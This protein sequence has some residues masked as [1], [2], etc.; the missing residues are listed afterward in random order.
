LSGEGIVTFTGK[1]YD[2]CN[3]SIW[4]KTFMWR[5]VCWYLWTAG[6]LNLFAQSPA[7]K[8]EQQLRATFAPDQSALVVQHSISGFSPFALPQS[9]L[10]FLLPETSQAGM[11]STEVLSFQFQKL[12]LNGNSVSSYLQRNPLYSGA[13][14]KV[15]L[16]QPVFPGERLTIELEYTVL[17]PKAEQIT[18]L[19]IGPDFALCLSW[20]P[21]LRASEKDDSGFI[22]QTQI[23]LA[24]PSG[25]Q[26]ITNSLWHAESSVESTWNLAAYS[27]NAPLF[28]LRDWQV[29]SM[30]LEFADQSLPLTTVSKSVDTDLALMLQ[31]LSFG[32]N[33][34]KLHE[35]LQSVAAVILEPDAFASMGPLR[36]LGFLI[37]PSD[38]TEIEER[39]LASIAAFLWHSPGRIDP[40]WADAWTGY[41]TF[42]LANQDLSDHLYRVPPVW[43][44]FLVNEG[45]SDFRTQ[46]MQLWQENQAWIHASVHGPSGPASPKVLK[47]RR[48]LQIERFSNRELM[49]RWASEL[50]RDL[51]Q[52]NRLLYTRSLRESFP[53]EAIK[54]VISQAFEERGFPS[55]EITKSKFVEGSLSFTLSQTGLRGI[56]LDIRIWQQDGNYIDFIWNVDR[57][58][59]QFNQVLT[60][61]PQSIIIDPELKLLTAPQIKR[62]W[63]TGV[64]QSQ[65][66]AL[67]QMGNQ[68]PK[69]QHWLQWFFGGF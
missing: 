15:N 11:K 41:W 32:L 6:I 51:H 30:Q 65:R 17:F 28:L 2:I 22:F 45:R 18:K 5:L 67:E 53:E 24:A 48:L 66:L 47:G 7:P 69:W 46:V 42:L 23:E 39:V 50:Q 43:Q 61:P 33:H 16:P 34:G 20:F 49:T 3:D 38:V 12:A 54:T 14:L 36:K 62:I 9:E 35:N 26:L 37:L 25:W 27:G 56:P 40:V 55:V 21:Q 13:E 1:G 57:E 31:N 68:L 29:Q 58:Q 59:K 60:H 19:G 52:T 63:D 8:A 44:T 4:E 10:R 64:S